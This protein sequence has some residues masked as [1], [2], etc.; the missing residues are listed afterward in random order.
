MRVRTGSYAAFAVLLFLAVPMFAQE[1][2]MAEQAAAARHQRGARLDAEQAGHVAGGD[3]VN[4]YFGFT[5]RRLPRWESLGRGEM[6]VNEAFG[7][8][9]MGLPAGIEGESAGRVFGMHDGEGSSVFLAI[10]RLPPGTD[11]SGLRAKL[12]DAITKELPSLRCG[13]E[14]VA[15]G[16]AAHTFAAFRCTNEIEGTVIYQAQQAIVLRDHLITITAS[17]PSNEQLT[18]VLRQLRKNFVWSE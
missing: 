16:D 4:Q 10:R 17:A 15:L 9:A 12:Q 3:Y 13:N 1:P 8:A 2:S 6:N 18:A 7:R 14:P 5:I 11:V